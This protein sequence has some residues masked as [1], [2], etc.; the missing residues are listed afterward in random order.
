MTDG[1]NKVHYD[2]YDGYRSGPSDM[3]TVIESEAQCF[4]NPDNWRV[5]DFINDGSYSDDCEYVQVT[6]HYIYRPSNANYYKVNDGQ[7]AGVQSTILPGNNAALAGDVGYRVQLSWPQVWQIISTEGYARTTNTN[8]SD[9]EN[10][11]SP[12]SEADTEMNN[13]CTIAKNRGVVV[14]TIAF[15]A[16]SAAQTLLQGCAS[17]L[18]NYYDVDSTDIASAFSAIA[19]SIQKLKLTQ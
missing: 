4:G 6:N 1:D 8:T 19:M 17:S 18:N 14:Y 9:Y 2:L 5:P 13:A 12:A 7:S 11:Y 16:P 10:Q 3:Y 15:A